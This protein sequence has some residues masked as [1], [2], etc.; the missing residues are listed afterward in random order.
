MPDKLLK[1]TTRD[2][3]TAIDN[4]LI[5]DRIF[6]FHQSQPELGRYENIHRINLVYKAQFT[7]LCINMII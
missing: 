5:V 1:I 4:Q 3:I 6:L 2:K 7:A